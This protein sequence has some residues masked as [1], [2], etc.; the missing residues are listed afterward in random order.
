[1]D[2]LGEEELN[3]FLASY[4][5]NAD[6]AQ[7]GRLYDIGS[8]LGLNIN[9]HIPCLEKAINYPQSLYTRNSASQPD[10]QFFVCY[11]EKYDQL[12]VQNLW[13][14]F[15]LKEISHADYLQRYHRILTEYSSKTATSRTG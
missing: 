15:L 14:G 3:E 7:Y 1:M 2:S 5:Q 8:D 4:R 10:E 12:C 9:K 13:I 6:R 11:D